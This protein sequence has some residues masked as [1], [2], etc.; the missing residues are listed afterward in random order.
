MSATTRRGVLA[1][2]FAGS[3]WAL[4][5]E[6]AGAATTLRVGVGTAPLSAETRALQEMARLAAERSGGDLKIDVFD[7]DKLGGSVAQLENLQ[8]GTQDMLSNVADWYQHLDKGWNALAIPFI[9]GGVEHVKRFQETATYQGWLRDMPGRHGVRMLADNWYRLPRV[10]LTTRPVRSPEDLKDMRLR[11]P[12][13]DTYL[14][15][16]GALGAKP[17][18]IA[19]SEAFLAMKTGTV[20]GMEAPLSGVYPQ[21]F[22]QAAPFITLTMHQIAPYTVLIS[23]RT[24]RRLNARHQEIVGRAARDAGDWYYKLILDSFDDQKA[25]MLAEGVQFIETDT[26]PWADRVEAVIRA[27]ETEGKLPRGLVAEIRALAR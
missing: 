24:W 25:R 15:T 23:E 18:V 12:D 8:L 10:L 16:W 2:S 11:M 14:R 6:R 17:T 13:L 7:S 27:F 1:A 26:R 21:K 22:Y 9:F 19:F 5:P 20:Q 4:A 3:A